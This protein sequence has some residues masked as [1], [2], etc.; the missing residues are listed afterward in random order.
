MK[1]YCL[2]V[3]LAFA[4]SGLNAQSTQEEVDLIQSI[5]GMEKKVLVA[6]FVQPD[7]YQKDAFWQLYDTYEIARDLLKEVLALT[8][9]NNKLVSIAS[10]VPFPE[11]RN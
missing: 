8:K 7:A 11:K 10:N 1:T 3:L 4:F 9:K 2:L 5:F 6:E